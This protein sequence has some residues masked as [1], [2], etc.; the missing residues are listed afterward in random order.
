LSPTHKGIIRLLYPN[1][2]FLEIDEG[3]AINFANLVVA[4]TSVYSPTTISRISKPP[5]W[6]FVDTIEFDWLHTKLRCASTTSSNL[7][8]K[9]GI[10]RNSYSRRKLINANEWENLALANGYALIDPA[11]LN[12]EDEINLFRNATHIIGESGS[13]GY[14]SGLNPDSQVIILTHD[15][16]FIFWNEVSQL[17]SLRNS[18]F[19]IIRGRRLIHWPNK[20]NVYNLHSEWKLTRNAKRKIA[21]IV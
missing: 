2:D 21:S 7:P 16:D 5:D 19:R 10:V 8:K 9:I 20:V 1:V 14:L 11:D 17:N 13:W 18:K 3:T 4:P 15:K 12:A 6:V